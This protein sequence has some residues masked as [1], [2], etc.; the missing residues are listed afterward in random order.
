MSDSTETPATSVADHLPLYLPVAALL[1]HYGT[2][3]RFFEE[4]ALSGAIRTIKTKSSRQ[5][6]RVYNRRDVEQ[7]LEALAA[8]RVPPRKVVR[9]SHAK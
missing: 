2:N 8:G 3:R 6:A 4:L 7:V 9:R 5:G 1:R